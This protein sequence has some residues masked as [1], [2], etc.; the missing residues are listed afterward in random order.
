MRILTLSALLVALS[1]SSAWGGIGDPVPVN[2]CN[3]SAK[4]KVSLSVLDV[5]GDGSLV[6]GPAC[7]ND[8]HAET[9]ITCTSKEKLGV[10]ADVVIQ[11]FDASGAQIGTN[12]QCGIAPGTTLTFHTVPPGSIMPLPWGSP[13]AV[14]GYV[15]T[16]PIPSPGASCPMATGCFL[17][18]SAR[19]LTTSKNVQC[20]ATRIDLVNLCFGVQGPMGLK[21]WTIIKKVKQLG[22]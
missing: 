12:S 6:A 2:P 1:T 20:T 17:H 8:V 21:E 13:L 4:L 19:I 15:L 7:T 18:G 3:P 11:Y 5:N 9:A 22:D 10:S 14:P 16:G